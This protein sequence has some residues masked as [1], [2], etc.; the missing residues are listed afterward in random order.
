[1]MAKEEGNYKLWGQRESWAFEGGRP[2]PTGDI[3]STSSANRARTDSTS[4]Y[5]LP[6]SRTRR[7]ETLISTLGTNELV[8]V[9]CHLISVAIGV[10]EVDRECLPMVDDLKLGNRFARVAVYREFWNP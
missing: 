6:W 2:S 4:S 8:V 7:G 1:M 9:S 3:N 5:V 10:A